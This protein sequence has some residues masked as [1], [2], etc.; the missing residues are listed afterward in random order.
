MKKRHQLLAAA[1]LVIMLMTTT[2]SQAVAEGRVDPPLPDWWMTTTANKV[3]VAFWTGVEPHYGAFF[4]GSNGYNQHYLGPGGD[5]ETCSSSAGC[6]SSWTWYPDNVRNILLLP[7]AGRLLTE[8]P[9][10]PKWQ[11]SNYQAT[12]WID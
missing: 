6:I 5:A 1:A 11:A 2:L 7:K 9:W 4:S 10:G 12:M 3:D 8:P